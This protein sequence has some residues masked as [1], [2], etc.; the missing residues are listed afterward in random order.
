M[1]NNMQPYCCPECEIDYRAMFQRLLPDSFDKFQ[2]T[3]KTTII[4]L[5]FIVLFRNFICSSTSKQLCT[6][7]VRL[8]DYVIDKKSIL[9][10][11]L[12]KTLSS[13][14]KCIPHISKL[15]LKQQTIRFK[16]VFSCL[17][18]AKTINLTFD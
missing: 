4:K 12:Y 15:F 6:Y 9:K 18:F 1:Y 16:V 3:V 10:F 5:L 7:V 13:K 2:R 17:V 8:C 11:F 14:Y